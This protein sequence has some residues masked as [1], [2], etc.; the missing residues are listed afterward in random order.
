MITAEWDTLHNETTN[1]TSILCRWKCTQQELFENIGCSSGF[2][3]II[4][5]DNMDVFI[6]I[7]GG[8]P[9]QATL[10]TSVN[11][12]IVDG[13][14]EKGKLM[15]IHGMSQVGPKLMVTQAVIE[16]NVC[17]I[18]P[19]RE[20]H[21]ATVPVFIHV[22]PKVLNTNHSM[23]FHPLLHNSTYIIATNRG[24]EAKLGGG[25][26]RIVACT[27]ISSTVAM[28]QYCIVLEW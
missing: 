22:N 20:S 2:E 6:N 12:I 23:I 3:L 21:I 27:E 1:S 9:L 25:G 17:S 16:R 10:F 11:A 26:P 7:R 13:S 8:H 14:L 4:S 5:L 15:P 18:W 24:I 28:A 19:L